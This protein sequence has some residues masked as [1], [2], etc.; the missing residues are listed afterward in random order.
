MVLKAKSEINF[1][2]GLPA[3][4]MNF[5]DDIYVSNTSSLVIPSP[6]LIVDSKLFQGLP[7]VSVLIPK[8]LLGR[9]YL[10]PSFGSGVGSPDVFC[11]NRERILVGIS[12]ELR[13]VSA[14]RLPVFVS[15]VVE[16]G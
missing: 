13:S 4:S 15:M 10:T 8:I 14:R 16:L 11:G 5:A 2:D 1:F 12:P 7:L 3:S 6:S 9:I